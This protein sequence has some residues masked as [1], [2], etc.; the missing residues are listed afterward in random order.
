MLELVLR[1]KIQE[2]LGVQYFLV[3]LSLYLT[4]PFFLGLHFQSLLC[5]VLF[6]LLIALF[7]TQ[8]QMFWFS[9][10]L[11]ALLLFLFL[12]LLF[13]FSISFNSGAVVSPYKVSQ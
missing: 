4:H 11:F 8:P 7:L 9:L 12:F 1:K 2:P 3:L 13:F 5:T 6:T 10:S